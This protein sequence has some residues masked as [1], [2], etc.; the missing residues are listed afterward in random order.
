MKKYFLIVFSVIIIATLLISC[1]N[2][3]PDTAAMNLL[4]NALEKN[5][6][7]DS[8]TVYYISDVINKVSDKESAYTSDL[9]TKIEGLKNESIKM[10][11]NNE[12]K[13][14]MYI[15]DKLIDFDETSKSV[16]SDGFV[17]FL[18][19]E[20]KRAMTEEE[21]RKQVINYSGLGF[22]EKACDYENIEKS[23][24]PDGGWIITCTGLNDNGRTEWL[25]GLCNS[26]K[27]DTIDNDAKIELVKDIFRIDAKGYIISVERKYLFSYVQNGEAVSYDVKTSLTFS[28]F[29]TTTVSVPENCNEFSIID[30]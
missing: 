23:V 13:G 6:S 20:Y 18:D 11:I 29:D 8:Y 2:S 21:A 26:F 30:F 16:Y 24:N 27:I 17:Y 25:D 4:D 19:T 9:T 14:N 22:G 28:D 12:Y 10:F 3:S 5:R 1:S 7:A 15:D